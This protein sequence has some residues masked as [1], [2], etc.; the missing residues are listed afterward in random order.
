MASSYLEC[1]RHCPTCG[2]GLSNARDL[3]TF[4][5]CDWK[6]GLWE[7]AS[8]ARLEAACRARLHGSAFEGKLKV[9]QWER[10]EDLLTWNVFEHLERTGQLTAFVAS[11]TGALAVEVPSIA[12]WGWNDPLP[13]V[14]EQAEA[15]LRECFDEQ[16]GR[17]SEPDL[18]VVSGKR[19]I[20]VEAKF[21][22]AAPNEDKL[23]G[24]YVAASAGA[25]TSV[26]KDARPSAYQLVRNWALGYNLAQRHG[27]EFW[28]IYLV[29]DPEARETEAEFRP[30]VTRPDSFK[31]VT[32][33]GLARAAPSLVP[34]LRRVTL[35][36]RGAFPNL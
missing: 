17:M 2:I 12:Y 5:R 9:M 32:W 10:S 13:P 36:F 24:K 3:P 31:R 33:E 21:D 19:L 35:H 26:A 14:R 25:F 27:Y 30:L 8:A 1:R 16:P 23:H 7:R 11:V 15:V 29:R 28:L 4:A 22:S 34:F 20:I 18:M 6:S